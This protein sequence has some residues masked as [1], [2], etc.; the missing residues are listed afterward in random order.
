MSNKHPSFCHYTW[1]QRAFQTFGF[2]LYTSHRL[3]TSTSIPSASSAFLI[4]FSAAALFSFA[5]VFFCGV[6]GTVFSWSF[7]LFQRF[8]DGCASTDNRVAFECDFAVGVRRSDALTSCCDEGTI[9]FSG[10]DGVIGA[11]AGRGGWTGLVMAAS[12][13]A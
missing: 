7:A 9:R 12:L 13:G 6:L 1:D 5:T 8:G 3:I 10:R 2:T 11:F 4:L